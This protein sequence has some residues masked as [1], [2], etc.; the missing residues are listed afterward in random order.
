MLLGIG[1]IVALKIISKDSS[2][3]INYFN[4]ILSSSFLSNFQST[5]IKYNSYYIAGL[6][7]EK[8]FLGNSMAPA[9]LLL[10][11]YSLK[12]TSHITMGNPK[13]YKVAWKY[14]HIYIDFPHI[15]LLDRVSPIILHSKYPSFQFT[16]SYNPNTPSFDKIVPISPES[17]AIRRFD[18]IWGQNTLHITQKN[19]LESIRPNIPILEKQVD[20]WFCTD[21]MLMYAPKMERLIYLYYYRNQFLSIDTLMNVDYTAKTIDT[22]SIVKIS[23]D[24]IHSEKRITYSAPRLIVNRKSYAADDKLFIHSKLIADNDDPKI[25]KN[26]TV[27]DVYELNHGNYLFS[28]Y[29]PRYKKNNMK[30]FGIHKNKLVVL[31]DHYLATFDL[32]FDADS[33][34]SSPPYP[35]NDI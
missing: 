5:N 1:G 4:R 27:I 33:L 18:P 17:F 6:A 2:D 16:D 11:D 25:F 8:I 14:S 3:K 15:Y 7:D 35:A 9:H 29:I 19:T 10:T 12:D 28:F 26:N 31:Y 32:N 34:Q 23:L 21:G 30:N 24:T 22:V 13:N 20:G